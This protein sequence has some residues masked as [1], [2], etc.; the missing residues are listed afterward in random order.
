MAIFLCILS[1][2]KLGLTM[3]S[4]IYWGGIPYMA[5]TELFICCFFL[6][7]AI[8]SDFV[9]VWRTR[10]HFWCGLCVSVADASIGQAY[11]LSWT[12]RHWWMQFPE[13]SSYYFLALPFVLLTPFLLCSILYIY[14]MSTTPTIGVF[15]VI[16]NYMSSG[17][18][19]FS[20]FTGTSWCHEISKK[21]ITQ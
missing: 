3:L 8:I 10:L 7:I 1:I 16:T 5:Y 14:S 6:S 13:C 2:P 18:S 4:C 17:I 21:K 9:E 20:S 11:R 15:I 12:C 19:F